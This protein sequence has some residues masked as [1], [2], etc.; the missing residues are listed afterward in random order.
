[1][2][3]LAADRALDAF[4]INLL[5]AS[6]VMSPVV[7]PLSL[8]LSSDGAFFCVSVLYVRLSSPPRDYRT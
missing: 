6:Y 1:V 3:L 7:F 8:A 2:R 5:I 4:K